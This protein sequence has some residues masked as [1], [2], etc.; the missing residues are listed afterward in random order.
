MQY[1]STP[2]GPGEPPGWRIERIRGLRPTSRHGRPAVGDAGDGAVVGKH[3]VTFSP[4]EPQVTEQQRT[5]P[6]FTPPPP[7]YRG[8]VPKPAEVE[9]KADSNTI[10]LELVPASR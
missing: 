6:K 4:P 9:V 2:P 8:L 10:D 3:R 5:N 1:S 7:P